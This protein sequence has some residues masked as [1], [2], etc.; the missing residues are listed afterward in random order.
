MPFF[1]PFSLFFPSPLLAQLQ[2]TTLI[3]LYFYIIFISVGPG[4]SI[5]LKFLL[6]YSEGCRTAKSGPT[7]STQFLKAIKA[8]LKQLQNNPQ[9][10]LC[11]QSRNTQFYI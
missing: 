6:I 11:S 4:D 10:I 5:E 3:Y 9:S 1:A 8:K 7:W 2:S